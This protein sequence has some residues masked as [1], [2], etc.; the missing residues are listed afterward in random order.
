MH[1]VGW[2]R[3]GDRYRYEINWYKLGL[4]EKWREQLNNRTMV[5][6]LRYRIGVKK[7]NYGNKLDVGINFHGT[8]WRSE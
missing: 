3:Y 4:I 2:F 5:T 7:K 6:V 1:Q 8:P